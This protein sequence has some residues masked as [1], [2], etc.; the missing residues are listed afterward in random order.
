MNA[1]NQ[2]DLAGP[3]LWLNHYKTQTLATKNDRQMQIE[4][5]I[6]SHDGYKKQGVTP[7]REIEFDRKKEEFLITDILTGTGD[8][9]IEMPFHLH[10]NVMIEKKEKVF[11]LQA[12]EARPVLLEPDAS[13]QYEIIRGQEKPI[14]GWYSEHFGEKVACSVLYAKVKCSTTARFVTKIRI[15]E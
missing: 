6:A 11:L 3:T 15:L 1:K 8:F 12:P 10:P 13:L 5:V 7:I 14:L 4:K 9:V 2:A